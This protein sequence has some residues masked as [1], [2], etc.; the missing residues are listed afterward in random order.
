[1]RRKGQMSLTFRL[2]LFRIELYKGE[3]ARTFPNKIKGCLQC[4]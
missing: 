3:S 4:I 2:K 1:M